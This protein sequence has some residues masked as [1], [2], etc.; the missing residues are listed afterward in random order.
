VH[1][2]VLLDPN[3]AATLSPEQTEA[4]VEELLEAERDLLPESLR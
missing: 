1:Q 2:A 3:A 4:M